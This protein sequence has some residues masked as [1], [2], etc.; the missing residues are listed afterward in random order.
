MRRVLLVPTNANQMPWPHSLTMVNDL[1]SSQVEVKQSTGGVKSLHGV[2]WRFEEQGTREWGE[3][4][5]GTT[6]DGYAGVEAL[7]RTMF[8]RSFHVS[9]SAAS[10]LRAA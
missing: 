4:T 8:S 9:C 10:G 1:W 2:A 6:H 3:W 7:S 5:S